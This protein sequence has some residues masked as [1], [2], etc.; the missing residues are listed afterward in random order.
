MGAAVRKIVTFACAGE[1]LVGTHDMADGETGL[2]IVSGGNEIRAGAHRAM[3]ML[4][5]RLADE[6][7]PVFRFDRRGVGDSSGANM[8]HTGARP[9]IDAAIQSFRKLAPNVTRLVGF[10][11]CDGATSLLL[12]GAK[13]DRLVLANPWLRDDDDGL[14]SADAIRARYVEKVRDPGTWTRALSGGVNFRKLAGGL[15]KLAAGTQPDTDL[16]T[17]VFQAL[18]ARPDTIILISGGDATGITFLSAAG[19][20][21]L[22]HGI[23]TIDTPSHSFARSGDQEVLIDAIRDAVAG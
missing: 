2:L 5:R 21:G 4:A 17:S 23:R 13:V 8:G 7:T 3:A 20:H 12:F 10:G 9:D 15:S 19:R 6:G 18:R 11:N 22:A 16:E 1:T 14:P